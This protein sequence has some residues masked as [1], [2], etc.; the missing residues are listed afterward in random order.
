MKL[1][2][3]FLPSFV[4]DYV[5]LCKIVL[6]RS[7]LCCGMLRCAALC[8]V[9]QSV[10]FSLAALAFA[11]CCALHGGW[12]LVERKLIKCSDVLPKNLGLG[13]LSKAHRETVH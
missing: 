3:C 7:A 13:R 6:C 1:L 2:R 9:V 5:E 12:H 8:K 11:V 10:L 4:L